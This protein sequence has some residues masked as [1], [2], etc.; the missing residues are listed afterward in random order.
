MATF[1]QRYN[2]RTDDNGLAVITESGRCTTANIATIEGGATRRYKMERLP[3]S[4]GATLKSMD[5]SVPAVISVAP[6]VFEV[7]NYSC[8]KVDGRVNPFAIRQSGGTYNGEIV[9]Q[10]QITWQQVGGVS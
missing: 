6:P 7:R 1:A 8:V 3:H 4:A 5:G 9:H 10:Y 2:L